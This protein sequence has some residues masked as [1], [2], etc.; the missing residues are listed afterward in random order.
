MADPLS[1]EGAPGLELESYVQMLVFQEQKH[2]FVH[3]FSYGTQHKERVHRAG[4]LQGSWY[5][6]SQ[7]WAQMRFRLEHETEM[8]VSVSRVQNAVAG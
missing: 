7:F 6:K 1:E 2:Y 3:F 4:H 8:T 5:S